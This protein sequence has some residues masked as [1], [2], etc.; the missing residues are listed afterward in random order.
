M[1]SSVHAAEPP[2]IRLG[3]HTVKPGPD[4]LYHLNHILR[5]STDCPGASTRYSLPSDFRKSP[6]GVAAIEMAGHGATGPV[7]VSASKAGTRAVRSIAMAYARWLVPT[8]GADDVG[9]LVGAAIRRVGFEVPPALAGWAIYSIRDAASG[10]VWSGI[11][12]DPTAVL[13]VI[14]KSNPHAD[15][16]GVTSV[17]TREI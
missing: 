12:P 17:T 5:A 7:I 15:F 14:R 4:G 2:S 11:A 10:L 6:P 1:E 16:S 9:D 8:F 13:A 3:T